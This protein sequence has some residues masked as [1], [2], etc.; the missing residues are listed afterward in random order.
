MQIF[1]EY[2][3]AFDWIDKA[4]ERFDLFDTFDSHNKRFI[5][6]LIQMSD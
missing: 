6:S 2:A 5:G 1:I 3:F 4:T